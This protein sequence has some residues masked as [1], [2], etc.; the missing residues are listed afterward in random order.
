MNARSDKPARGTTRQDLRN[1][2][3][4]FQG[5]DP[6]RPLPKKPRARP[7]WPVVQTV[8]KVLAILALLVLL[9]ETRPSKQFDECAQGMALRRCVD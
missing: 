1:R 4:K 8:L 6:S 7:L 3:P 2:T 5:S 9:W